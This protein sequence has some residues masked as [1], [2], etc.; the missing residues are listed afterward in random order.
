MRAHSRGSRASTSWRRH[1]FACPGRHASLM[2]EEDG[3]GTDDGSGPATRPSACRL[4]I[5]RG[6]S[7]GLR[8]KALAFRSTPSHACS[9]VA[10]VDRFARL[11]LRGQLRHSHKA[12]HRIP[13]SIAGNTG[14]H[15]ELV[16]LRACVPGRLGRSARSRIRSQQAVQA[17]Q[18]AN[19]Y[20]S[21][22]CRDNDACQE[23]PCARAAKRAFDMDILIWTLSRLNPWLEARRRCH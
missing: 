18:P 13:V 16:H 4:G 15:L 2:Q 12:A 21:F 9:T 22:A 6:R 11:P 7:P 19:S 10:C 8:A 17:F 1:S 14:D 5:R 23:G 3:N 20:T